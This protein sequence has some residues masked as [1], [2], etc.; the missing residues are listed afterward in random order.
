[1]SRRFPD[2]HALLD[3]TEGLF[4]RERYDEAIAR[5]ENGQLVERPDESG[6]DQQAA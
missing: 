4:C 2:A 6:G 3:E 1:M 5:C